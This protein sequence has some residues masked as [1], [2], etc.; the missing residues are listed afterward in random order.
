MAAG[1]TANPDFALAQSGLP[2]LNQSARWGPARA[3]TAERASGQSPNA[4]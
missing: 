1:R 4:V 2:Q 3:K